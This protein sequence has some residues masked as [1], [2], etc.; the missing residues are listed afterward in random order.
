MQNH[1]PEPIQ[2]DFV[3]RVSVAN[4]LSRRL[5][6]EGLRLAE[7]PPNPI[8][9]GGLKVEIVLQTIDGDD[10]ILGFKWLSDFM[11]QPPSR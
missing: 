6:V 9:L 5:I 10:L 8:E 7:N 4:E 1:T 3:V 2:P 11:R